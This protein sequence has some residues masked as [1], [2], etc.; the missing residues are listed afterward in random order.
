MQASVAKIASEYVRLA[1]EDFDMRWTPKVE[2]QLKK[3]DLDLAD[4]RNALAACLVLE[5][6]KESP[7]AAMFVVDGETSEGV[8]LRICV[9]VCV[10]R[11]IYC[12]E[13]VALQVE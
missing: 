7:E 8:A 6:E 3:L 9:R 5:T 4:A 12:L 10:D 13:N 11:P 2:Q 1:A